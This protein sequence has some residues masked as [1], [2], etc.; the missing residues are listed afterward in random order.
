[1]AF[2]EYI[3]N[4]GIPIQ[5]LSNL[6]E[7]EIIRIEK[8]LIAQ[9]RMDDN[10]D[11][12]DVVQIIDVLRK[13]KANIAL[14][15]QPEFKALVAI[16]RSDVGFI[17]LNKTITKS[18]TTNDDFVRFLSDNFEVRF[19]AYIE[20]CLRKD[21]YYALHSL[22]CFSP[23]LSTGIL[24]MIGQRLTQKLDFMIESIRLGSEL[25]EAKVVPAANPFY[26]R[27]LNK[28][29]AIQFEEEV[30]NL[31]NA[32]TRHLTNKNLKLRIVFSIGILEAT[33]AATQEVFAKNKRIAIKAGVSEITYPNGVKKGK[34]GTTFSRQRSD[35]GAHD[36][37]KRNAQ[38]DKAMRKS[39][40]VVAEYNTRAK[41][42]ESNSGPAVKLIGL[43]LVVGIVV[44]RAITVS[45]N[46]NS[47]YDM[48]D[49][50]FQTSDKMIEK[51]QN[52]IAEEQEFIDRMKYLHS[53]SVEI[54]TETSISFNLE[55]TRLAPHQSQITGETNLQIRNLTDCDLLIIGNKNSYFKQ[56][57]YCVER[58]QKISVHTELNSFRIYGGNYPEMVNYINAKG[59]TMRH[60]RFGSMT[61]LN[62]SKLDNVYHTRKKFRNGRVRLITISM[63]LGSFQVD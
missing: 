6:S 40:A 44:L 35:F 10:L 13:D 46:K 20:K 29:G 37:R 63:F 61:P 32:T 47:S 22:L 52:D 57:Y 2:F 43:I 45:H 31:L 49:I 25:I 4:L 16:L 21:H 56:K 1:V 58:G 19:K 38:H 3:E 33:N 59:D 34:G 27:C 28:I 53:D 60:F 62:L 30:G 26:F 12:N 51:L 41:K 18:V 8:R 39:R 42:Q 50:N 7:E 15:F 5:E 55:N 9:S 14:L 54:L 24:G 36:E 23:V 48:P 17:M 11:R